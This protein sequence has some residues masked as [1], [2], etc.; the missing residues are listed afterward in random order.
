MKVISE[1]KLINV[2]VSKS[3]FEFVK[4]NAPFMDVKSIMMGEV[5]ICL[6]WNVEN[7]MK[8]LEERSYATSNNNII[9]ECLE[10]KKELS[11]LYGTM[12]REGFLFAHVM[13][14]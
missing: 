13:A 1:Y 12:K 9:K 7:M 4:H 5:F 10:Q 8:K 11:E 6:E 3:T 2:R 14:E